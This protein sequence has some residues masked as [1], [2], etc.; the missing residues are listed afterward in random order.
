MVVVVACIVVD[1]VVCVV[2]CV[3]VDSVLVNVV[4]TDS[5]DWSAVVTFSAR[6]EPTTPVPLPGDA[7][8]LVG[9]ASASGFGET[10]LGK[11]GERSGSAC[12][13]SYR[14][15]VERVFPHP[16][17]NSR[18]ALVVPQTRVQCPCQMTV[19]FKV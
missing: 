6:V 2:V 17:H 15:D 8:T 11:L 19:G 4:V 14:E 16:S 7:V 12:R 9:S 10:V 1:G 5:V 13:H 3:R 18:Q